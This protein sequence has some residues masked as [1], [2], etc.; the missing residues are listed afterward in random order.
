MYCYTQKGF[1]WNKDF[2]LMLTYKVILFC[3]TNIIIKINS[4]YSSDKNF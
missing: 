4:F 2:L 1:I 3:F